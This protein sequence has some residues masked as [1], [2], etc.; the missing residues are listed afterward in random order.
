MGWSSKKGQKRDKSS[1]IW[2]NSLTSYVAWNNV[3]YLKRTNTSLRLSMVGRCRYPFGMAYFQG[4]TVRF[5][6]GIHLKFL[7]LSFL[8]VIFLSHVL[9]PQTPEKCFFLGIEK[10]EVVSWKKWSCAF[11]RIWFFQKSYVRFGFTPTNVV[12]WKMQ[13]FAHLQQGLFQFF[14]ARNFLQAEKKQRHKILHRKKINLLGPE[15]SKNTRI[16]ETNVLM[17]LAVKGCRMWPAFRWIFP[18]S[19]NPWGFWSQKN[20]QDC[21]LIHKALEGDKVDFE[22]QVGGPCLIR[23]WYCW[24][25]PEIRDSLTHQLRSLVGN[26]PRHRA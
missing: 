24:W 22:C 6:E 11:G 12:F 26:Y 17:H 20:G 10:V 1:T 9:F 25:V 7:P 16:W 5:R 23:W 14:W 15:G 13:F 8:N 18:L 4:R 2:P 19:F 21:R 3:P